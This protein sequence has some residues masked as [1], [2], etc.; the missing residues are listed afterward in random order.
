MLVQANAAWEE[1]RNLFFGLAA[2]AAAALIG[3][4]GR[5]VTVL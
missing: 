1:D 2:A 5:L 3:V 4:A